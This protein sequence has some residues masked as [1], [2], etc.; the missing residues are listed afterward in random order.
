M[1]IQDPIAD[2]LTRLRNGQAARKKSIKLPSSKNKVAIVQVLQEEGYIES[3]H[4]I[5]D[6]ENKPILEVN[7]KYHGGAPVIQ[8]ISRVSTPGL[9]VYNSVDKLPVVLNGLGI[10]IISTSGGIM[11]DKQARK[12][13]C[14]GEVLCVVE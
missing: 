11:S 8:R 13:N 12:T 10:A 7:L 3:Y 5:E 2:L 9:R 1:S 6:L 4:V 14:G